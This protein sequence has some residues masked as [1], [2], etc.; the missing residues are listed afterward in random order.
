MHASGRCCEARPHLLDRVT[1]AFMNN[2]ARSPAEHALADAL[3][4]VERTPPAPASE[5]L[6]LVYDLLREH[7][8]RLM[9]CEDAGHPLSPTALVHE[10]YLRVA[11]RRNGF[12]SRRHFY[13]AAAEAM[14]RI[15][16][17]HARARRAA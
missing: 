15:L 11:D 4:A 10:A 2:A 12:E 3:T 13:N 7:A 5:L 14:R 17:D 9:A 8:G 1:G 6:P 16:V